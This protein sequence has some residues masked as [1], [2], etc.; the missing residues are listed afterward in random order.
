MAGCSVW[1]GSSTGIYGHRRWPGFSSLTVRA[2][3]STR[4]IA[5]KMFTVHFFSSVQA[6]SIMVTAS[7]VNPASDE[8]W[9][10]TSP[11]RPQRF[12]PDVGNMDTPWH[13]QLGVTVEN[14]GW[15]AG[16]FAACWTRK[17]SEVSSHH[18]THPRGV[19]INPPS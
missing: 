17:S 19:R 14:L 4:S 1:F 6:F 15:I 8:T 11:A 10:G 2:H 3:T 18:I 5:A 13:P 7:T 16:A 9:C 12:V